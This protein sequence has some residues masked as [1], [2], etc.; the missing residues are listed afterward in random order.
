M[1]SRADFVDAALHAVV[2]PIVLILSFLVKLEVIQV[3]FSNSISPER[4]DEILFRYL[5][6]PIVDFREQICLSRVQLAGPQ[7]TFHKSRLYRPASGAERV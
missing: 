3:E 5:S 4:I 2:S 6:R 1:A 7:V